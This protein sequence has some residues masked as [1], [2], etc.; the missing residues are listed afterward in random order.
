MI[1]YMVSAD[2]G[3]VALQIDGVRFFFRNGYGD[4][5]HKCTVWDKHDADSNNRRPKAGK[6]VE[7]FEVGKNRDLYLLDYDC[8]GNPIHRFSEGRWFV[9][10]REGDV[11]IVYVDDHTDLLNDD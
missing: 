4:G 2:I 10:H 3:S 11:D 1:E 6:F 9:Y 5:V 7:C 8:G